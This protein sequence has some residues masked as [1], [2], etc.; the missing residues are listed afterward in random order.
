MRLKV[1]YAF[2]AYE[3]K[4]SLARKKV[5]VL[6][7][8]LL[9][10]DTLPYFALEQSASSF[11][12]QSLYP[13]IW[14]AGV[15]IPQ[16]LFIQFVAI[17]IGA[18]AMSEEYEQGTAE[19][20]LSK[21]V[22]KMEYVVGKFLGGYVLLVLILALSSAVSLVSAFLTFGTQLSLEILPGEL[23]G[24][25]FAA[26]LFFALSFMFGELLRR[27]S[28]AYIFS[29]ALLF[30]SLI[31]GFYLGLIFR[32]TGNAFYSTV[33]LYLPTEPVDSL[34]VQYV[35]ANLPSSASALFNVLPISGGAE[36][37]IFMSAWLITIY[38]ICSA[39]VFLLYFN[40]ADVS[41]RV[42]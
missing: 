41:R 19:L 14:I 24:T 12:P 18:G 6:V 21:P 29:S 37:S 28:L 25:A 26:L 5:L 31:V 3:M 17:F 22:S 11:I 35:S 27:S 7:A 16:P 23:L 33:Q 4:R 15:L 42:S 20:L 30:T 34:P 32:L 10:L 36:T 2:L 9:L 38:S 13:Y 8:F 39:I 40:Y 1:I